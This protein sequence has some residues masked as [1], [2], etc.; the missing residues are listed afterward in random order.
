MILQGSSSPAASSENGQVIQC[1]TE[2]PFGVFLATVGVVVIV[3][4][5]VVAVIGVV[6]GTVGFVTNI[7]VVI[8]VVVGVVLDAVLQV[9]VLVVVIVAVVVANGCVVIEDVSHCFKDRLIQFR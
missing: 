6:V 9:I 7:V 4:V 3:V 1:V 8:A 2:I 5:V